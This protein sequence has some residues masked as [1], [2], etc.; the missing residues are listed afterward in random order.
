[1]VK[2]RVYTPDWTSPERLEYTLRLARILAALLPD[3][4]PHGSISTLPLAWRTP[5]DGDR[6]DAVRRRLDA[7]AAG[8]AGLDR[9]IRVGFEPEPGCVV[10]TSAD[11]V[12]L[13]S[14]VDTR[15]L[16]VC[17]DACHLAVGFEDPVEVT[18]RLARAGL[19]VI[20]TQA[21]CALQAHPTELAALAGF[22]EPRFLHQTRERGGGGVD[23]LADA[24]AGG[25]PGRAPWRV[26][27]HVPVHAAPVPPLT[28]TQPEL[29]A[30]L[31]ALL[32]GA[33]P[34]TTHVEVETYTWQVLHPDG[35]LVDG[36]AREL[37]WTRAELRA[38]GL[39]EVS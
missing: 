4:V 8:L 38:L 37:D 35:D 10:D 5:W 27:Y 21:S 14:E 1:V 31:G 22:A 29:R 3:D 11:A 36:L 24:L 23:D 20:K 9:T 39:V 33:H 12:R 25:L 7:L 6:A 19:P 18:G 15:W 28:S 17:L 30:T 16:G 13:L 32:A 2:H 26:H 34:V